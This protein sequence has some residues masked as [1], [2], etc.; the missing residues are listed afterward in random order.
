MENRHEEGS[1]IHTHDHGE[2]GHFHA[3]HSHAG[4]G[5]MPADFGRAFAIGIT[6]NVV[7]VV[8]Q[9]V[10]GLAAHSLALL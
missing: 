7:Y 10:F 1:E 2:A 9:A 3:G 6:L 4:H 5:H 8:A